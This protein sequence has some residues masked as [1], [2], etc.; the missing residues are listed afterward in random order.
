MKKILLLAFIIVSIN[1][2]SQNPANYQYRVVYERLRGLMPDSVL[3]IPRYNGVPSGLRG[4]SS[5]HDGAFAMDTLNG[6]FYG[7]RNGT[8]FRVANY[9]DKVNYSD[10]SAMNANYLRGATAGYGMLITGSQHKTWAVDSFSLASRPALYKVADSLGALIS[11]A[12]PTLQQAITAGPILTTNNNIDVDNKNLEFTD[13]ALFRFQT[14]PVAGASSEVTMDANHFGFNASKA[15]S[16]SIGLFLTNTVSGEGEFQS[17]ILDDIGGLRTGVFGYYDSIVFTSPDYYMYGL[18]EDAGTKTIRYNP[19][20]KKVSYHDIPAGGG[21]NFANADLT[22]TADRFHQLD[23]KTLIIENGIFGQLLIDG[24]NRRYAFGDHAAEGN[25]RSLIILD[26]ATVTDA[27]KMPA[28]QQATKANVVYY[29]TA[30]GGLTY[31]A[32]PAGGG[33]TVALDN[34][35]AVAINAALVLGTS[36]AFALGSTTKHWSDLFLAEGGV[37]NWDNGDATLTQVGNTLTYENGET[38]ELK[39]ANTGVTSFQITDAGSAQYRFKIREYGGVIEG[40]NS[41]FQ[42]YNSFSNG[43]LQLGGRNVGNQLTL[44]GTYINVKNRFSEVQ[45]AD[46]ASAAGA[47]ALGTD[48][49]SFEITGTSPITLISNVDW[50]NGATITLWFTSTASLTDGTANSGTDIGIELEGNANFTA[51]AG[52]SVTLQLIEIGGTQ[53]WRQKGKSLN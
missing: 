26:T 52:Q 31:D 1:S 5:T 19:S 47:I 4:G 29:N 41:T 14:R 21:T 30:T 20:T 33:A 22:L 32:A 38:F 53:R 25:G 34:L 50:Q 24:L 35:S 27:Y 15:T 7:Y 51:A 43:T 23:D 6:N 13:A 10:T 11:G 3:H 18:Q 36:D 2:F 16:S 44:G 9:I 8:W 40:Y 37:I 17:K 46:V 48:G 28:M 49:N 12:T 42:L 45:G 39:T